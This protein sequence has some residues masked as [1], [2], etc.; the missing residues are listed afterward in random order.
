MKVAA[1][2]LAAG[3]SSRFGQPKQLVRLNGQALVRQ[4][5]CI[6]LEA[7]CS[8]VFVVVGEE[9]AA[10]RAELNGLAVQ[11]IPNADWREG[12]ASSIR[13]GIQA[14][15]ESEALILL[16]SDQPL[17]RPVTL[18]HLI[19][20][21]QTSNKRIVASG[22]ADTVGIPA[23]FHRTCFPQLLALR[24]DHGAKGIIL[25]RPNEVAT[26]DFPEGVMDLDTPSDLQLFPSKKFSEGIEDAAR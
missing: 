5:A 12:I 2:I 14:A 1:I 15:M 10:I 17:V 3:N 4:I 20:L 18:A 26:Y 25:S 11:I 24:G 8:P 22:Y 6:T 21:H 16:A 7:K 9:E 19:E 13:A 23:L